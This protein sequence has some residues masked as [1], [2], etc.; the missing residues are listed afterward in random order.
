MEIS[1]IFTNL[2]HSLTPKLKRT[3]ALAITC[4]V[5]ASSTM[6]VN[7]LSNDYCVVDEGTTT[8]VTSLSNNT[9]KVLDKAGV[10]LNQDDTYVY[11]NPTNTI[12][13][14]RAFDVSVK[15]ING[16]YHTY[17]TTAGTVANALNT[18]GITLGTDDTVSPSLNTPLS[19]NMGTITVSHWNN[20][21]VNIDNTQKNIKVATGTVLDTA[22]QSSELNIDGDDIVSVDKNT[23]VMGD[24]SIDVN[25]A[26]VEDQTSVAPVAYN[27]VKKETSSLPKGQQQV[28]TRGVDG[29]RIVTNRVTTIDGEIA[30]I[31][32][33]NSTVTKEA[34][35]E[36]VLVGTATTGN[37]SS[38]VAF[39]GGTGTSDGIPVEY[40][41][42]IQGTCTAY[43][44]G[45]TCSTGVPASYGYVAVNP[46]QIPYGTK[47]YICSPDGSV[48]YGYA[49][50]ADT[51]GAMMSGS[52]MIDLYFDTQAECAAFGRRTMNIYIL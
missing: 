21:T 16:N 17:T 3:A 26:S 38:S 40:S 13:V 37:A 46:N 45:G 39:G 41:S 42:L 14:M 5:V 22:L 7:A 27:T 25:R 18:L 28:E 43:T 35:D 23:V 51:G 12:T 49:I 50:A 15:D 36:V 52:A 9:D 48:V 33:L 20:V 32:E 29:E 30:A 10:D 19:E 4:S 2:N 44:G 6:T 47:M 24:M 8:Y 1:N 11:D 34:T 31:E